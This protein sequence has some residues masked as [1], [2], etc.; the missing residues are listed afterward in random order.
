MQEKNDPMKMRRPGPGRPTLLLI[1]LA[2]LPP[3]LAATGLVVLTASAARAAQQPSADEELAAASA[4][5]DARRYADAARRLDAFLAAHPK[6]SKAGAAALALGRA[7]GEM[8]QWQPAVSAYEKAAATRDPAIAPLAQMGLGEAAVNAGQ[9]AKA[10]AALAAIAPSS[11]KPAQAAVVQYLLG[12][13][14]FQIGRFAQAEQAYAKVTR[15]FAQS[16]FVDGAYFGAGVSA[17]RQN[18]TD[19][20]RQNLR[21][22]VERF[23][24]ST[25]RPQA[26]ILLAQMDLDA[27]RL[28]EA[29]TGFESFLNNN[30]SATAKSDAQTRVGAE[31]GLVRTLL[32]LKDYP[33]AA[34][35]LEATLARLPA[36]S[37]QRP[38]V[39]L[40]LGHS[41]YRQTQY[42]P[43]LKAYR[44]AV[45]SSDPVVAAEGLYWGANAA[46]AL[47][48]TDEANALFR[49]VTQKYPKSAF[50]AKASAALADTT[51]DPAQLAATLKGAPAG[52][53]RARGTLRLARLY[54]EQKMYAQ[55]ATPLAALVAAKPAVADAATLA[56]AWYLLGLAHEGQNKPAPA[57]AALASAVRLD[58]SAPWAADANT[59]LAWL[60]LDQKKPD[61]AEAAAQAAIA[62]SNDSGSDEATRVQA[63]LALMQAQLDQQ[64]WDAALAGAQTL[65][66]GNPSP[67]TRATV[68][69]TQAWVREKRGDGGEATRPL[70][71]Q[72]ARDYPASPYAPNALLHL[73][74]AAAK[75]GNQEDARARYAALLA[76]FPQSPFASEARF[77][78]GTALY[79]LNRYADAAREWDA[80]A[81]GQPGK[82]FYAPEAL[83]W[84]GVALDKAGR[85]PDAIARLSR[86]VATYPTH[87]R[88]AN[89]RIRLAALK[90]VSGSGG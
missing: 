4:L 39:A 68:L 59:R 23:P 20:A 70:W 30:S 35:R 31:E 55:A 74:D 53:N 48:R 36:K 60:Y 41:R 46:L 21:A 51:N 33:A 25:D 86:L 78:L 3:P 14:N 5:F 72:L 19:A 67:E 66:A 18:K 82:G 16:E 9:Y 24:Q 77:K 83:Y 65:L 58:A 88:V 28:A 64:K 76:A 54:L 62:K 49:Q 11:L 43:A 69:F 12:Q 13:A 87:A 2:V 52:A 84:A 45:A 89:A 7:R 47:K 8:K 61:R 32:A 29:R 6:H 63:R 81:A 42:E 27:G 38:H 22:V 73:G 10:A 85:K 56:E 37:P 90:A 44:E 40:S 15:D 1:A 75:S 50:A 79:T 34:S 57:A 71:E 17:L 80:L 26:Q